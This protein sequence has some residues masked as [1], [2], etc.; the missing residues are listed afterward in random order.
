M[1]AVFTTCG[2]SSFFDREIKD[3]VSLQ[4]SRSRTFTSPSKMKSA[5]S[6]TGTAS[7]TG[8]SLYTSPSS[9]S[10]SNEP[11]TLLLPPMP[12]PTAAILPTF[13]PDPALPPV[14]VITS[15]V[16]AEMTVPL[17]SQW[18]SLTE[19]EINPVLSNVAEGSDDDADD[20]QGT[21]ITLGAPSTSQSDGILCVRAKQVAVFDK[22]QE[23]QK[24]KQK[25]KQQQQQQQQDH[26]Q[27]HHHHH[28][29]NHSYHGLQQP[30]C[31]AR[32]GSGDSGASGGKHRLHS[33]SCVLV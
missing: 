9:L 29:H 15:G 8:A 1:G 18:G 17:S 33:N 31:C 14:P 4:A 26:S 20:V 28:R 10:D 22:E 23:Q 30:Q 27:H 11:L 32:L 7:R 5:S 12:G 2:Y 6:I 3:Q 19:S 13:I 25:Q 24:Q 16:T 21:S